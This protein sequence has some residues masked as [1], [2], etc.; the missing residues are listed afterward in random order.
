MSIRSL[1]ASVGL[2]A[3]LCA[4]AA[5]A[6]FAQQTTAALRGV[7][8]DEAG[9][10]VKGATVLIVHTPSGT[11]TTVVTDAAG[12]F[13]TRGLRV[14]GPYKVIGKAKGFEDQ[15]VED[16]YLSVGDA[17][18]VT[19]TFSPADQVSAVTVTAKK[20][21]TADLANVGS[22]T[23]VRSDAI[24]A[25]V[26]VKRDLRDVGR[27]DPLAD[28]DFVTRGSGPSGGL[29]VAGSTPRSNRITIDGVR[30]QDD[31]G[32][33]T[34]GLSTNRGP[35]SLEAVEQVAIS[36]TPFD[37]EEGD[38]TGG[39]L[40]MILKS[41]TNDFHGTVF[42]F[43][44][45]PRLLGF[46][47]PT[48]ANVVNPDGSITPHL[49]GQTK[50]HNYVH[51][52][53]Y[54]AFF[55]GPIIQDKLFFA[56]SY[57]KFQSYDITNAAGPAGAGFG[58]SFNAIPGISTGANATVADINAVLGNWNNY[59]ASGGLAP[60][61][62]PL[63]QPVKDEKSSV[64]IDWNITDNQ[65]LT[66]SYRHA[67][68]S[69][70][71][72]TTS[73][74]TFSLNSNWYAQPENEDN[75][76]L[77]LNSKWSPLLSTEARIS[78][79]GYQRGQLPPEGQNFANFS[80]CTTAAAPSVAG[81][82]TSCAGGVPQ[83]NFGPD[84][85]RQANALKTTDWAGD[86][87]ATYRLF[88]THQ[89]KVGYEFKGIH[90]YDLFVQ[91]AIGSYFF[92][93]V[94]DFKNGIA[95][96]YTYGNDPVT[97]GSNDAAERFSYHVHTL[98]AQDTWDVLSNLTVN[99]GVRYDIYTDD[100]KPTLNTNFVS[101][102]GF[103]NQTTYDGINVLM[104]RLSAKW[105]TNW[106]ELSGGVGLVS[107][108]L[109]DVFIGNS[110]G[111][112]TGALYN[113]VSFKRDPTTGNVINGTTGA[114]LSASD[115]AAVLGSSTSPLTANPALATAPPS[116][117]QQLI[118]ASGPTQRLA[119][120]NSIAPGFDMPS[121][122]KANLSFKT[123]RWH[124]DFGVDAVAIMS[125]TNI[126]FRDLR[127]RPLTQTVGG[128]TTQL[129][130]PDGRVRYDGLNI[131]GATSALINQNRQLLGLDVDANNNP[132]LANVGGNGDI[133]AYNP[134]T[135]NWFSTIAFSAATSWKGFD[136]FAAYTLQNGRKY[137]GVGEF[138]TTEGGNC[139]SGGATG[140]LYADQV[141]G[142]DPNSSV[143]GRDA[144]QIKQA[145]KLNVSYRREFIKGLESRFTLFGES[146]SGRP[147]TFLMSDPSTSSGRGQ[148]FGVYSDSA[149]LYVPNLG[150]PDASNP[151]KFTSPSGTT[152]YF[153]STKSLAAFK[154]LVSE[155]GL[156]QGKIVPKGFG[157]N[158]HV[159]RFD[160]QF[161]QEIRGP[162]EGHKI[163]FTVDIANLGNLL[164]KKWG[165]IKE[166]SNS[167]AGQALVNVSCGDA[168]GALVTNK[169]MNPAA[170]NS[171]VYQYTSNSALTDSKPNVIDPTNS[172]WQIELGL[173]Y[174]F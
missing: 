117:A 95:S 139:C 94:A 146:R 35:V 122:W 114:F 99:Y 12:V 34:G 16:I 97:L 151:L 172:L 121:D 149:L 13:D 15:T 4:L 147:I 39:A 105:R 57:E 165:V 76:A 64:K 40:N 137:G 52:Q 73:T 106:F 90:V 14:G 55:S 62:I 17:G 124:W 169:S 56:V 36:A 72:R 69:V 75:Y 118:Q 8:L 96:T 42:D 133:Q 24:E 54:G 140:N 136:I 37:V 74:T 160:L 104:P 167:R 128:V 77:Q 98:F 19:L 155:F 46:K 168:T 63:V 135:Q 10:P 22:R 173:K 60:G 20:R 163:I 123:S 61:G 82:N 100:V 144:D 108:G 159:D 59:A 9:A 71:K 92:D 115:G 86:L 29:Y 158:P 148:V 67:F 101:R 32:L 21:S 11:K 33:N 44:R 143:K 51:D 89:I 153:D 170:C 68:S 45:T 166:Y 70:E 138:A 171:Y 3:I 25:I 141:F 28:L 150:S 47:L 80:V 130:T 125:N 126:A 65:R 66:A 174:K 131:Q 85:F 53:N 49:F 84:Q 30:S 120:T 41:G 162:V 113:N 93:S 145:I 119:Y 110:Y 83:I 50:V 161:S 27:R 78:Y 18:K 102:Y 134:K 81:T 38:F 156:P 164:N 6:A 129:T 31:F 112:Q 43:Y 154:S 26:S 87:N 152:V 111:A 88:D 157:Q 132:D 107:G 103:N 1:S 58:Q 23:T 7:A 116:V 127:A 5:P 142:T 2:G 109:P 91:N 79:R 48:A